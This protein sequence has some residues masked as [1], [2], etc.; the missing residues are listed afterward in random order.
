MT[1]SEMVQALVANPLVKSAT[2]VQKPDGTTTPL[3]PAELS[4]VCQTNLTLAVGELLTF[5]PI[6]DKLGLRSKSDTLTDNTY[7]LS[8]STYGEVVCVVIGD[9]QRPLRK[10]VDVEDYAQWN[11]ET[12]GEREDDDV[13]D[14][15]AIG[16]HLF[17][18]DTSG[19]KL[20]TI[21]PGIGDETA[22]KFWYLKRFASLTVDLF[23]DDLHSLVFNATIEKI[24]KG[25][26]T[27]G[28]KDSIGRLAQRVT[29]I[30]G[31]VT[32]ERHRP[33][34]EKRIKIRNRRYQQQF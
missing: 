25:E 22:I 4:S 34:I 8:K 17:D 15:S 11:H 23:P 18:E 14:M 6:R 20:L 12:I 21:V 19:N 24:V 29:P 28:F 3:T 13:E 31:G 27:E 1:Q 2:V 32:P 10:F 30:V 7:T 33:S 16:F 9:A 26:F 5:E